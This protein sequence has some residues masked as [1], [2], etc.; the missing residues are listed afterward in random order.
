M[1]SLR[2]KKKQESDTTIVTKLSTPVVAESY[3]ANS[4]RN[5]IKLKRRSTEKTEKSSIDHSQLIQNILYL[6]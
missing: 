1:R 3:G 5:I 4:D 6:K 2:L